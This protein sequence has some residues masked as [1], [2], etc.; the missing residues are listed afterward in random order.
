MNTRQEIRELNNLYNKHK[1]KKVI[2]CREL[3]PNIGLA[4]T[5]T[6]MKVGNNTIKAALVSA[7]M[8]NLI[9]LIN[10]N[11][12]LYNLI[13]SN[14]HII[15]IQVAF[16]NSLYKKKLVLNLFT[17][18]ESINSNGLDEYKHSY[19]IS[20][21]ITRKIPDLIKILGMHHEKRI[22]KRESNKTPL[23]A[24]MFINGIRMNCIPLYINSEN[25]ILQ[26]YGN[27]ERVCS[28]NAIVILKKPEKNDILEVLGTINKKYIE[29]KGT[30]K[31]TLNFSLEEQ[32]PRFNKTLTSLKAIIN[33]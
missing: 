5:D 24:I 21:S 22:L 23:D 19:Y 9:V 16:I 7:T 6:L 25:L 32:S 13:Y 15:T 26:F 18:F 31:I 28:K 3:S 33:G 8:E 4:Q 11:D 30:Y 14:K 12:Y 2:F 1:D 10:I 17:R 29:S 20:L 27:P